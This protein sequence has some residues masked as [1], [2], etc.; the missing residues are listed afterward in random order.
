MLETSTSESRYR[1]GPVRR[2]RH[3]GVL[4]LNLNLPIDFHLNHHPT[5]LH[6]PLARLVIAQVRA[7]FIRL[8]TRLLTV[9]QK[10][11][12]TFETSEWMRVLHLWLR[13]SMNLNGGVQRW[14]LSI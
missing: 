1:Y 5:L 11:T 2:D 14:S 3:G 10:C 6:R 8:V 7:V 4:A 9:F 12:E 13:V